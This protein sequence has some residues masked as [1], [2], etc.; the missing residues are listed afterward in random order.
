MQIRLTLILAVAMTIA[1]GS[2]LVDAQ[3]KT[4]EGEL[5]AI[6]TKLDTAL[7]ARDVEKL[8]VYYDAS[9]VLE[10]DG[11]KLTR[12]ETIDQWKQIL[13]FIKSI[14]KLETKIEKVTAKDGNYLV[15]YSQSSSGKVQFPGSPVLP[16]TY[17]AKVTDTWRRDADGVWHN[18]ASVE[19]VADF[20]VNGESAKPPGN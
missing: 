2:I 20:K 3:T 10:S 17:A 13:G 16:F 15:D 8:T 5:R 6:Y 14:D 12:T 7:K 9:Y 1:I 4:P 18:I 19:H 11:K